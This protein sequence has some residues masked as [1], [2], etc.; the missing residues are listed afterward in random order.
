MASTHGVT[1]LLIEWAKG[2][3]RALDELTPLVYRELRQLAGREARYR[4]WG[5]PAAH[6]QP[7]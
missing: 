7:V 5:E 4:F 6:Q 2:D 3:A 1:R